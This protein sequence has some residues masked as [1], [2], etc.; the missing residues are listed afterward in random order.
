MNANRIARIGSVVVAMGCLVAMATGVGTI[1]FNAA[2]TAPFD[3]M[4]GGN[5]VAPHYLGRF[6]ASPTNLAKT[7]LHILPGIVWMAIVP[8]QFS[9]LRA[10]S[11]QAHRVLG[12]VFLVCAALAALGMLALLTMPF[13]PSH[14]ELVPNLLFGTLFVVSGVKAFRHVKRGNI[15]LHREW[16]IRHVSV[17][18]GIALMR[19]VALISFNTGFVGPTLEDAQQFFPHLFWMSF[20]TSVG[21]AEIW[22]NV[23]RS[24][25]STQPARGRDR[26]EAVGGGGAAAPV[27]VT[28]LPDGPLQLRGVSSLTFCG[29]PLEVAGELTL[30]RCGETAGPPFCDGSHARVAFVGKSE[31]TEPQPLRTWE[32]RRLRTHFNPNACMHVF[33]C[34]PLDALRERE[35]AGDEA[36]AGEIA[37]VV[38][39]CPSGALSYE[40][41][42]EL[43][44]PPPA[45]RADVEIVE[46]GELRIRRAFEID[47]PLHERQPN[48]RAT[49]CR[50]GLSKNKPWCDGRHK[51]KR[52]FR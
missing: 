20:V 52:G 44:A 49:L 32:G 35:L 4:L 37:R 33:Y 46:G 31:P 17:G 9:S 51:A 14:M 39:Q 13:S 47:A 16:I 28:V 26:S 41:D 36:A 34:K 3:L 23:T 43:V 45:S 24:N 25:A 48:D 7:C 42:A 5:G 27:G 19:P 22:I 50:C 12:R 8:L 29:T 18:M 1:F 10:R 21:I 40:T 11:I 2:Y 15:A 6:V 38:D 30:C